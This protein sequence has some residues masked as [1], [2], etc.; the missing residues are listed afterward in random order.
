MSE[1]RKIGLF[2]GSF[3]PPHLGHLEVLRQLLSQNLFDEIWIVPVFQHPFA[4]TLAP[5]PHRKHMVE[6]MM[7]ELGSPHIKLC[8]IEQELN[9]SPSYSYETVKALLHKHPHHKYH[10]IVGTDVQQELDKWHRSEEL[11]EMAEFFFVPRKGFEDSPLP[12]VS[13]SEIR[14]ALALGQNIEKLTTKAIKDY[15]KTNQLYEKV[16]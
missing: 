10:L 16:D 12:E 9:Q 4:K 14:E 11:Q 3:N 2:G 5:Y 15:I 7:S 13:S 8:E 6:L 1:S